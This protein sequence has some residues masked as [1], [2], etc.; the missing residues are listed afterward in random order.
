VSV[1]RFCA[2]LGIR[3]LPLV[4][5]IGTISCSAASTFQ[6]LELPPT[7]I[8]AEV[9]KPQTPPAVEAAP[10]APAALDLEL[11]TPIEGRSQPLPSQKLQKELSKSLTALHNGYLSDARHHLE[12]ALKL[13]PTS[14]NLYFV[15]GL[16]AA[17]GNDLPDARAAW[18]KSLSLEANNML[19]MLA[20]GQ[21]L[22]LREDYD[23]SEIYLQRARATDPNAWRPDQLLSV[24]SLRRHDYAQAVTFA[25]QSLDLGKSQANAA[26][27]PLAE[28]LIALNER[29]KAVETLNGFLHNNPPRELTPIAQQLLNTL[30]AGPDA[31][32]TDSANAGAVPNSGNSKFSFAVLPLLPISLPTWIPADVD[33]S[34]PIVEAGASCPMDDVLAGAAKN[35]EKFVKSVD[36]FTATESLDHELVDDWGFAERREKRHF[37][38][39]VEISEPRHGFFSVKEYRNGTGDLNQFPDGIATLGLPSIV[40]LFHPYFRDDYE[41]TC[42]GL[43]RW[44]NTPAWQVHFIQR[45][46]RPSLRSYR[47]GVA[48]PSYSVGLKGRVWIDKKTLQ[49]VR[50]ESDLVSPL[51]GIKLAAEHQDVEF[52]PVKFRDLR[53]PMWLPATANIYFDLRGRKFRRLNTFSDYLLFS[54]DDKQ[55]ISAPKET[56]AASD[57][58]ATQTA[59]P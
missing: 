26:R 37:D 36:H 32:V 48:G 22:L 5:V 56:E 41:L 52:A 13:D 16:I 44:K 46:G 38:Y 59:K 21:F 23:G 51:P 8:P 7:N 47:I 39:V 6:D 2:R 43:G 55:K 20:L 10:S 24:L 54:V 50:I 9:A 14:A 40:L 25:E 19:P 42:E 49:V 3:L 17:R 30:Q 18:E 4:V 58:P 12:S 1:L 29:A 57:V 34:M 31:M 35:V 53:Q 15:K 33:E 11:K 27:L 45:P 28:A